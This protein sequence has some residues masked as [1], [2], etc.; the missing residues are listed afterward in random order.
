VPVSSSVIFIGSSSVL[1]DGLAS[2]VFKIAGGLSKSN[3]GAEGFCFLA[4]FQKPQ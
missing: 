4:G 1:Q 2:D 3:F